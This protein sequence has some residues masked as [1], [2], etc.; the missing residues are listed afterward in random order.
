MKKWM[1]FMIWVGLTAIIGTLLWKT[2]PDVGVVNSPT[3][4]TFQTTPTPVTTSKKITIAAV[5]DI[6]LGR[7]TNFQIIQKNNPNFP[8]EKISDFI[9]SADIAVGNLE[10][11][12]SDNCPTVRTGFKFCGR[13]ESIQGLAYA[14]FDGMNLANNHINNY[15]LEGISQ[16]TAALQKNGID[17]FFDNKAWYK[18]INQTKF[19]FLGFDDTVEKII[20]EK[21]K[22]KIQETKKNVDVL[23][24]NFH[25]GVEYQTEP[26]ER[27]RELAK[28]AVDSGAD[29]IVGHHPHVIQP[30]EYYQEKPIFYSLGNFVF[31]QMWS[32]ET[33]T[34]AIGVITIENKKIVAARIEKIYM[35]TCCQPELLK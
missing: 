15:G 26:T 3:S 31:D 29:I 7:E 11:P 5:G 13:P 12:V 14:G 2:K 32:E 35:S 1:F 30:L 28:L 19:G 20:S 16:T 21:L 22:V 18:E 10:G 8:F 24:V 9:S 4:T 25:W 34:G 23:V 6:G 17:Y 27:Q 33:R